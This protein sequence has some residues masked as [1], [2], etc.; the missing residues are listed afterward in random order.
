MTT[1]LGPIRRRPA[2]G[3]EAGDHRLDGLAVGQAQVDQRATRRKRHAR[4]RLGAARTQ[5]SMQRRLVRV[6]ERHHHEHAP[7]R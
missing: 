2:G 3:A 7:A 4:D 1:A 5:L 6:L